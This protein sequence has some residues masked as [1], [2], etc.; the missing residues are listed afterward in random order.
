LQKNFF[1][2]D[3]KNI[4]PVLKITDSQKT[5]KTDKIMGLLHAVSPGKKSARQVEKYLSCGRL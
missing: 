1:D 3:T 2:K 4:M 5:D